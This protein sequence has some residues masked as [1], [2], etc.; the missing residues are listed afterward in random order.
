MYLG[1][2]VETTATRE[3]F[4]QPRHPYTALLLAAVPDPKRTGEA[5]AFVGGE[6]PN[7]LS[8][9]SGCAFHPRC[10]HADARCRAERPVLFA[11]HGGSEV[12]CHG[13]EEKRISPSTSRAGSSLR[14]GLTHAGDRL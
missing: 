7:P 5:R 6:V 13:I 14:R 11:W 4:A 8:P 3:L 12:A 9:P 1:R 2:I 10:P